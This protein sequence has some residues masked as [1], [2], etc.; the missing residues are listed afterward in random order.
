LL[1]WDRIVR[2]YTNEPDYFI[3]K[4]PKDNSLT[5]AGKTIEEA[6]YIPANLNDADL[7][8]LRNEA[9]QAA[10]TYLGLDI[11]EENWNMLIRTTFAEATHELREESYC[12]AVILNRVRSKRWGDTVKS[13]VTAEF[14]F[15]SVT[16]STGKGFNPSS[17][18]LTNHS[19]N[20][21]QMLYDAAKNLLNDNNTK[22]PVPKD[23]IYFTALN[24]KAYSSITGLTFL[25]K[26]SA[27][28]KSI[29][30]TGTIFSPEFPN[31]YVWNDSDKTWTE[32]GIVV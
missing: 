12:M 25:Y 32:N 20:Q 15:E 27:Y 6:S 30:L 29:K 28:N 26:L 1:K 2:A 11:N 24:Q 31:S 21:L 3:N 18:Y 23:L 7:E 17:V 22:Q 14:Q 13:V 19:K 9:W 8:K 16:G 5:F 4:I 10:K